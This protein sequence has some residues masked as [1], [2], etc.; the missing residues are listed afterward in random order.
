MDELN[1]DDQLESI[2]C[3][4]L[5]FQVLAAVFEVH[6]TLGPGFLEAV[7]EKAL[8]EELQLRGFFVESQK[9]IRITYKGADVGAYYPDIVVENQII[10]ELKTAEKITG[11]HEAQLLHYLK[12]TGMKLGMV[13]NFA[14]ERVQYK[15]LVL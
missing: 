4:D 7:Y 6:N 8:L 9:E 11:L 12:A 2:I 13:I 5:S 15:R 1:N 3:K 14:A 10:L